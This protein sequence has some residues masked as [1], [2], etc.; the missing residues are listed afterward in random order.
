MAKIDTRYDGEVTILD[1]TGRLTIGDGDVV[2]RENVR[3]ALSDGSKNIVLNLE[4]VTSVDSS[5]IGEM[6]ASYTA[7]SQQGG[8]LKL[9]KPSMKTRDLLTITRLI[10]IFEVF[11]T[12]AEAVESYS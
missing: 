9:L 4:Q 10:T 6:V 5:G 8:K 12:E 1:I 2:L 3:R 7:T 11:D